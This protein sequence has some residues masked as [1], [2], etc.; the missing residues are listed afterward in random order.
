MHLSLAFGL[1][2]SLMLSACAGENKTSPVAFQPNKTQPVQAQPDPGQP[3]PAQ[4]DQ[5]TQTKAVPF[6]PTQTQTVK[7]QTISTETVPF[8]PTQAQAIR[9]QQR[10]GAQTT[11]RDIRITLP[12]DILFDFDKADIRPDA[13]EALRQTL[14]VI[15]YYKTRRFGLR[16]TP[17]QK[18]RMPI[19]K[20][21]PSSD[22]TL[23]N[24]GCLLQVVCLLQI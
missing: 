6:Q 18:D 17:I 24:N 7:T 22:R 11:D 13:A 3:V 4:P 15:R 9:A 8:Q 16:D 10:L 2:I 5:T 23:Y 21:S 20:R 19:T 1:V 12:A 14:T